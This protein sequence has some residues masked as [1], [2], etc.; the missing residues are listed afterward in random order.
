MRKVNDNPIQLEKRK[1]ENAYQHYFKVQLFFFYSKSRQERLE[2]PDIKCFGT[3]RTLKQN[4]NVTFDGTVSAYN[5]SG[6]DIN[7]KKE[8]KEIQTGLT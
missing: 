7:N 4:Q 5:A 8:R 6:V 3:D 2:N 1:H